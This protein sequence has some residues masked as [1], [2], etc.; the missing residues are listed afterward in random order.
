[1][2]GS[3]SW[4]LVIAT[5]NRRHILP[6]CLTLAARQTRPPLQII[7]IDASDDWERERE[8]VLAGVAARHPAIRWDYVRA[9]RRSSAYQRNQGVALARSDVVFL[10]DDD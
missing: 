9:R 6:R 3:L 7:V 10:I 1:M 2:P 4:S 8:E 5:C